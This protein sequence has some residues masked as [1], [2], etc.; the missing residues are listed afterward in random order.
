MASTPTSPGKT[1]EVGSQ[2]KALGPRPRDD[3]YSLRNV[4]NADKCT[5]RG[6]RFCGRSRHF[7]AAFVCTDLRQVLAVRF[8]GMGWPDRPNSHD[9][10]RVGRRGTLV[11]KSQVNPHPSRVSV[12]PGP[13]A[14]AVIAGK[15]AR[16]E[17][18]CH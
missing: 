1:R 10:P 11:L 9:P 8:P 2:R 16:W 15:S 14:P 13:A 4:V 7:A 5:E 18:T 6:C 17:K 12:S 3:C